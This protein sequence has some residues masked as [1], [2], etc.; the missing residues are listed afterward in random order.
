MQRYHRYRV[1]GLDRLSSER[2]MLLVAYHGRPIA[3]DQCLLSVSFYDRFGYMPHGVTHRA[4]RTNRLMAR[5]TDGLGF[6]TGDGEMLEDAVRRG[7]HIAVQ[8]GGTR[9]GCRSVRYRYQVDWGNRTGFVRLALRHGLP[10][11]PLAA[12]GVDDCYL[13]IN[14][15]YRWGKRLGLP[16]GLPA[17]VGIGVWGLWPLSPP[18]PVRI[19]TLIGEPIHLE[20]GGPIDTSDDRAL[21]AAQRR[22][23]GAV[24]ALL[25]SG[26]ASD[27]PGQT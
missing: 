20:D 21:L 3:R 9:E 26:R 18:F 10:V 4:V 7:E 15:G 16:A 25:D 11:V 14:N 2:S 5:V 1:E 13:G 27:R 6:V 24:Q 22:V 19:T 8:P 23:A 17:W 12:R